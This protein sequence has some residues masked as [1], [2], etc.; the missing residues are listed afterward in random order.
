MLLSCV[1]LQQEDGGKGDIASGLAVEQ[2]LLLGAL[3]CRL[4]GTA[5]SGFMEGYRQV[6]EE[7]AVAVAGK[8]AGDADALV[9]QKAKG[10]RGADAAVAAAA[11][12]PLPADIQ[13][14]VRG[15][16]DRRVKTMP[17]HMQEAGAPTMQA[18]PTVLVE[19]LRHVLRMN[20]LPDRAWLTTMCTAILP[21]LD[22]PGSK[23]GDPTTAWSVA[24]LSYMLHTLQMAAYHPGMPFLQRAAACTKRVL[25]EPGAS[26]EPAQAGALISGLCMGGYHPGNDVLAEI[27]RV[28]L[29]SLH[30]LTYL[31]YVT[32][33]AQSG[34]E[35]TRDQSAARAGPAGEGGARSGGS[36]TAAGTSGEES[37]NWIVIDQMLGAMVPS[38]VVASTEWLTEMCRVSAICNSMLKMPS[39]ELAYHGT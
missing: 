24:S 2:Q 6:L 5:P 39:L 35:G 30:E 10:K 29:P 37:K 11:A 20:T 23:L 28:S 12:Q 31:D 13:E 19:C 21:T 32:G 33:S 38:N 9:K 1:R 34:G 25:Q 4:F 18:E 26:V 15:M 27:Y 16:V 17:Q 3:A 36:A 14:R 7:Q 22:P 8:A